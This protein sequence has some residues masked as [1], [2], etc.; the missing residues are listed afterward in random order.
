MSATG[1]LLQRSTKDVIITYKNKYIKAPIVLQAFGETNIIQFDNN[2]EVKVA[3]V[4]KTADNA[5]IVTI[6]PAL[7][8][9]KITQQWNSPSRLALA[10]IQNSQYAFASGIEGELNIF[11]P[12]GMWNILLPR[13]I[14]DGVPS[15]PTLDKDGVQPVEISFSCDLP[16]STNIGAI[17]STAMAALNLL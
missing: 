11:S 13:F 5:M 17:A 14:L 10:S 4:K 7:I 8:T 1:L 16:T 15:A 12:S 2:G 9:G 3:N 6:E